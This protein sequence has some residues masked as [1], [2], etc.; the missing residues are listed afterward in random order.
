M[1]ILKV[2]P[3]ADF[4]QFLGKDIGYHITNET[5]GNDYI[6]SEYV[7]EINEDEADFLDDATV[8]IYEMCLKAVDKVIRENRFAEFGI[9]E[10]QASHIRKSWHRSD[11]GDGTSRDP[12]LYGRIDFRW[13]GSTDKSELK[14][15]EFNADTPTTAYECSTVQWLIVKDLMERGQLP[16]G[17]SQFNSLEEKL[18]ERFAY[19]RELAEKRKNGAGTLHLTAMSDYA[20]D[21]TTVAYLEELAQQAGWKTKYTDIGLIGANDDKTSPDYGSLFDED[22]Q[23]IKT[24][25]S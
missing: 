23:K 25:P 14:F 12:E 7:L 11:M 19:I 6:D 10:L 2:T 5:G 9:G 20:E 18:I 3:R 22:D 1:P 16:A 4:N 13:T 15:F 21:A 8:E 17:M 24:L